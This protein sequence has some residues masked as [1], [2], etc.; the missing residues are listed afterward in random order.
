MAMNCVDEL[1]SNTADA[2]EAGLNAENR[3]ML[4]ALLDQGNTP[5]VVRQINSLPG[6]NL[7]IQVRRA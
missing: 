7:V 4:T 5:G 1:L 6:C 2:F 3:E